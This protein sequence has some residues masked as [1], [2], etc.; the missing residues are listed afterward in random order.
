M[1]KVLIGLDFG[2]DSVRALLVDVEGRELASLVQP[3]PRWGW[4]LYCDAVKSQ[5]RQHP[6]DYLESLELA[7]K[8]VLAGIDPARVA[9]IGIDTTGSTPC[10]TDAAGTP[11][12]LLPEFAENPDA[13]FY[14]WK[15]HTAL[16]EAA[17]INRLAKSWGGVDYTI[18]EGGVYSAEWFWSK[19][20]HALRADD[21]V[22]HAA[23]GVIEHCDWI[24]AELTGA[25]VKRSR[26]AAGHK[27][28]WHPQWGGL[29][30]EEFLVKLDPLLAGF[31]DRLYTETFTADVPVGTLSPKWAAKLGL[32]A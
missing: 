12:A 29:P 19:F 32:P 7:V 16:G 10:V 25:P 14:L 13:M 15:D 5:F 24:G 17:E 23:G 28:M 9:G 30:S 1:E 6:L 4:G 3:Y 22:R 11:L 8:G 18:Y 26:C 20:L 27:A 2:T 31:R 21:A